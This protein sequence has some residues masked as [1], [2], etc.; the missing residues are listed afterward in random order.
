MMIGDRQRYSHLAIVLLAKLTAVLARHP[1]R[2]PSLFGKSR[3]IDDPRLDRPVPFNLRQH[4]LAHLAQ[5]RFV[6]PRANTNK[7]QQRLVLRRYP[8]RSRLGCHRLDALAFARQYQPGAI[9]AQRS[10]PIRMP[11]HACQSFDI[12]RKPVLS[13]GLAPEIHLSPSRC[14]SATS[15][16]S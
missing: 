10:N 6:R 16:M 12:R 14:W 5:H 4:Y 9:I 1:D 15:P 3:V 8:R 11:D 13:I 7:M 2:M